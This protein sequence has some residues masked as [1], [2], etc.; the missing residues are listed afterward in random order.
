MPE[1]PQEPLV[2]FLSHPEDPVYELLLVVHVELP[3]VHRFT[4]HHHLIV[5]VVVV[6]ERLDDAR[7]QAIVRGQ[8]L[9]RGPFQRL[10]VFVIRPARVSEHVLHA[11][12]TPP[13][14]ALAHYARHRPAVPLASPP[15][16]ASL[17]AGHL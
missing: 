14:R 2:V 15:G 9:D 1:L 11:P 7:P 5:L 17:R 10:F 13:A 12:T 4:V 16:P 6:R 8:S 3:Q